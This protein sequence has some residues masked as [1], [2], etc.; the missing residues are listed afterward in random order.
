MLSPAAPNRGSP[1]FPISA[2]RRG[3]D[4]RSTGH[5]GGQ[6]SQIDSKSHTQANPKKDA[7]NQMPQGLLEQIQVRLTPAR[8]T[9]EPHSNAPSPAV[10]DPLTWHQQPPCNS[11]V[12]QE[13]GHLGDSSPST[14]WPCD[15]GTRSRSML[16]S[17]AVTCWETWI[18]ENINQY[19]MDDLVTTEGR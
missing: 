17:F 1:Q 7:K 9:A 13:K 16:T 5:V 19:E 14:K 10:T 2:Y 4:Q 3:K 6:A 18:K 15:P 12:S 11:T 8:S